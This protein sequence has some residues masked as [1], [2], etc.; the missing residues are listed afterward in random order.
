MCQE[1]SGNPALQALRWLRG[2]D[3]DVTNELP[4]AAVTSDEKNNF[5]VSYGQFSSTR[6]RSNCDPEA[7][8]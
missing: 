7:G 8:S 3:F 5:T 2:P 4:A 6:R 1:K